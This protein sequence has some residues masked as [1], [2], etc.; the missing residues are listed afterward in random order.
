MTYTAALL[1]QQIEERPFLPDKFP[2]LQQE[3][4]SAMLKRRFS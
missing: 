2:P 4:Q 3:Q 1:K